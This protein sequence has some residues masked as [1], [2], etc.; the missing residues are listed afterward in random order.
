MRV[1]MTGD[2]KANLRLIRQV[3]NDAMATKDKYVTINML[4]GNFTSINVY[5][6][7][8]D[9]PHWIE[10]NTNTRIRYICSECGMEASLPYSYCPSCGEKL[11]VL[12]PEVSNA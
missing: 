9:E 5:P 11:K 6:I 7:S 10:R 4:G 2:T 12:T 8:T 3:I 1:E